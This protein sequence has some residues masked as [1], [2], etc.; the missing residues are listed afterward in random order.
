MGQCY[1]PKLKSGGRSKR[2]VI[3][4]YVPGKGKVRENTGTEDERVARKLLKEREGRVA[5]GASIL[6]RIDKVRWE[7][8]E[9][10]LRAFYQTTGQRDLKEYAYRVAHLT[11]FFTGR[12]IASIKPGDVTTY[13]AHRQ[14][15]GAANATVRR[16]LGTLGKL[17]RLAYE[18]EKLLR[19]PIIRKPEEGPARSGFFEPPEY[20]AV[21]RAL[22]ADLQVV[23]TLAHTF[24][25]RKD[26]LLGLERRQVDLEA[27]TV[28]LDPGGT[29]NDEGRVIYLTP[30]TRRLLEEQLA[31]VDALQKALGRI[32]PYVFPYLEG[33]Y[34]GRR[35]RDFR[36]A[37]RTAC[38]RAGVPGRIPHDFRRTGVRNMVNRGVPERVAMKISGHKTRAVFDRYHIVS[39]ADLL[40]AVRKL[41]GDSGA[42]SGAFSPNTQ[43]PATQVVIIQGTG[44]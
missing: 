8:A 6:P 22:R 29:K 9:Q 17:L 32:I 25:W 14:A 42:F 41:A 20:E 21:R 35:I 23:I 5:A 33:Q 44:G 15:Q 37:W 24:G 2:W 30:E 19:L 16:E 43:K 40:D 3:A 26:E 31:R 39:P 10:D 34:R 36:K 27:G 13:T 12:R 28:R 4:Y 7:E 1:R 18:N 11:R 38:R